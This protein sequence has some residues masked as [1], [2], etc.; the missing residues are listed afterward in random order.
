M[1]QMARCFWGCCLC[2]SNLFKD[3]FYYG[4]LVQSDEVIDL[5][6][7]PV[8][9]EPMIDRDTYFRAQ[10]FDRPMQVGRSKEETGKHAYI[11]D[12]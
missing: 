2:F 6:K 12:A 4:E 11:T 5:V 9:F 10:E 1:M 3:T 8:P 7:A